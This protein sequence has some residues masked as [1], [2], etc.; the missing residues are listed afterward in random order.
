MPPPPSSAPAG[1]VPMKPMRG[2]D[3][4]AGGGCHQLRN[5]WGRPLRRR[6]WRR[7]PPEGRTPSAWP[8]SVG[9][10]GGRAKERVGMEPGRKTASIRP[11]TLLSEPVGDDASSRGT[12]IQPA[13]SL[14]ACTIAHTSHPHPRPGRSHRPAALPAP[15]GGPRAQK[16]RP[17]QMKRRRR[18]GRKGVEGNSAGGEVVWEGVG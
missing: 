15:S 11:G 13:I 16:P 2:N 18:P 6:R 4:P 7:P 1:P 8:E 14:P 5:Q 12:T 10:E 9:R 3:E 17:K